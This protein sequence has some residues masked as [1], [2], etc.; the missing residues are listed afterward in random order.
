M[1]SIIIL[2]LIAFISMLFQFFFGGG[3]GKMKFWHICIIS[4]VLW[5]VTFFINFKIVSYHLMASEIKC[6]VPLGYVIMIEIVMGAFIGLTIILQ[7]LTKFLYTK[8]PQ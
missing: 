1:D 2:F 3:L 6:G 8:I 5:F 4:T 7:I